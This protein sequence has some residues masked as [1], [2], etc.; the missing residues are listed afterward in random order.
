MKNWFEFSLFVGWFLQNGS[1]L[2]SVESLSVIWEAG[3]DN[4]VEVKQVEWGMN[5]HHHSCDLAS[6]IS[7]QQARRC[8]ALLHSLAFLLACALRPSPF[9]LA[10]HPPTTS[11]SWVGNRQGR[12]SRFNNRSSFS[13]HWSLI[14]FWDP[15]CWQQKQT[16]DKSASSKLASTDDRPRGQHQQQQQKHN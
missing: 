11:Q 4:S 7:H 8:N 14:R 15:I 3:L 10:H 9:G 13:Y 5:H 16:K 6:P 1:T 2:Q 12:L